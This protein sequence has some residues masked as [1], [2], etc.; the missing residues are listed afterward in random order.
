[1][2]ITESEFPIVKLDMNGAVFSEKHSAFICR[3]CFWD[4]YRFFPSS[5]FKACPALILRWILRELRLLKKSGVKE[6]REVFLHP[7]T[8]HFLFFEKSTDDTLL[9]TFHCALKRSFLNRFFISRDRQGQTR[10]IQC[11]FASFF[12]HIYE[13]AEAFYEKF[14]EMHPQGSDMVVLQE[15][16]ELSKKLYNRIVKNL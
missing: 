5:T 8:D 15:E 13:N 14:C 2:K 4:Q 1:M 6:K 16:L 7:S 12:A 3:M 9:I 10:S 11:S